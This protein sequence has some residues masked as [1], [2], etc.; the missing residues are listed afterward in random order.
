MICFSRVGVIRYG[1]EEKYST[2]GLRGFFILL[3]RTLQT[4]N[5][6]TKAPCIRCR[7]L[8]LLLIVNFVLRLFLHV[9]SDALGTR[10]LFFLCLLLFRAL[11]LQ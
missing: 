1:T 7:W 3:E 4:K 5:S 10:L 6:D 9:D 8:L 2:P 11:L